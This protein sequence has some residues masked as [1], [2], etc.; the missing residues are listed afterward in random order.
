[1]RSRQCS[2]PVLE[3]RQVT[4]PPES[5]TKYSSLPIKIGDEMAGTLRLHSQAIFGLAWVIS[6][7]INRGFI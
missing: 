1:M 5:L 7:A 6:S 3:S 2:F 4:I